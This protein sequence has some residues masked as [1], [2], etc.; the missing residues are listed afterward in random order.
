M[1]VTVLKNLKES[2]KGNPAAHLKNAIKYILN[3]E[4]TENGFLTGSNCGANASEIYEAMIGTKKDLE[5][6]WGRQ[7]YHFVISFKP[8]D[9]D[10]MT[11]MDVG[12]EFCRTYLGDD[13]QYV[14]SV[15]ND[16]HHKHIHIVFNSVSQVSGLKYRYVK[17]D[18][19]KYIQPVTDQICQAHGLPKLTFDRERRIGKSYA[20]HS[21]DREGKWTWKKV[22]RADMDYAIARSGSMAEFYACMEKMGYS[23]RF[24]YSDK[25]GKNYFAVK[26]P[27]ADRARRDYKLG[28]GYS[29]EDIAKRIKADRTPLQ[30]YPAIRKL[31]Y[32]RMGQL[33]RFQA[34]MVRRVRQATDWHLYA[35]RMKEQS[36]VHRDLLMI[37]DLREECEYMLEMQLKNPEELKARLKTVQ[38]EISA[39]KNIQDTRSFLNR[40]Y[41]SPEE[42]Q[43]KEDYQKLKA[44][45]DH[46]S[47]LTDLEFEALTD[48]MEEY[49]RVYPE[50]VLREEAIEKGIDPELEAF[51][52]ERKIIHRILKHAAETELVEER[53]VLPE[54]PEIIR[55]PV[56]QGYDPG[57]LRE[58]LP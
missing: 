40:E 57:I 24:G 15:H 58:P 2:H 11:A 52:H 8:G 4:K 56:L 14:F 46:A 3:P 38:K 16:H 35:L 26:A 7:G 45:L 1:A 19:E 55:K 33:S 50:I 22:I 17:G 12:R 10:D 49:E 28:Y 41:F 18:W 48:D 36:R 43:I 23:F 25:L 30:E 9:C 54:D 13:Y 27:G 53:P 29:L 21:A 39:R 32:I 6:T 37:D 51:R 44:Q 20:E 47:E 31:S 5:K 34:C 42:M